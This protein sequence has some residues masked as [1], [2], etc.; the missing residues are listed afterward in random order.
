MDTTAVVKRTPLHEVLIG[1]I[2][3]AAKTVAIENLGGADT[4][5]IVIRSLDVAL[6]GLECYVFALKYGDMK[7]QHMREVAY[8]L[9][10]IQDI[11]LPSRSFT[12][13]SVVEELR[14]SATALEAEATRQRALTPDD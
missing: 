4:K 1:W 11:E 7:P 14:A 10:A 3:I 13:A 12:I 2:E 6:V 5:P 9:E 8:R